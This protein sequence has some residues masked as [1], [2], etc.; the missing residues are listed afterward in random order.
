VAFDTVGALRRLDKAKDLLADFTT[1]KK[2]AYVLIGFDGE[3]PADAERRC[4]R[5]YEAEFL[6]FAMLYRAAFTEKR[7]RQW[8]E[9]QRKWSRP[10]AY[11]GRKEASGNR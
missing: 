2:R 6:P 8:R 3:S 10:A 5:V 1:A 4:E 7:N 9:L 11:R